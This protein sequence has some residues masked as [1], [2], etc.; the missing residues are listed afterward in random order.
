VVLGSGSQVGQRG[1]R[2]AA[3]G[4]LDADPSLDVISTALCA[5]FLVLH[6]YHN[7]RGHSI[8]YFCNK[9]RGR[10]QLLL[11]RYVFAHRGCVGCRD[12]R[13]RRASGGTR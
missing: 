11:T 7:L 9:T 13:G 8:S 1:A 12:S 2:G 10:S 6:T 4:R 3:A 5:L